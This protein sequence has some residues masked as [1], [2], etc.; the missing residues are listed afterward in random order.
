MQG[1]FLL[2]F[3]IA[4]VLLS[5]MMKPSKATRVGRFFLI[6]AGVLAMGLIVLEHA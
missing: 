5:L 4:G 2:S 1:I 3:S 6:S